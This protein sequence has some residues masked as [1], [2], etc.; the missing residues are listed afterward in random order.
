[1]TLPEWKVAT[2]G[3]QKISSLTLQLIHYNLC[4]EIENEMATFIKL[5]LQMN[6]QQHV[7]RRK[8]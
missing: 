6:W 5:A 7:C 3:D 8:N 4:I 1:M 2:S